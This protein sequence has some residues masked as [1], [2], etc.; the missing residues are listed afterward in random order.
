MA[1]SNGSRL[2]KTLIGTAAGEALEGG[3]GND[4]LRGGGGDDGLYGNAGKDALFGGAGNDYLVGGLGAD[5]FSG[6]S[7]GDTLNVGNWTESRGDVLFGG[8]GFDTL[9]ADFSDHRSD[10]KISVHNPDAVHTVGTLVYSGVEALKVYTGSGN[11]T[12]I[13]GRGIDSL[14]SGD[15]ND[16]IS[17]G[18]GDDFLHA[19]AGNDVVNGGDGNDVITAFD[20]VADSRSNDVVVA[21]KGNDTIYTGVGRNV[22]DAGSGNDTVHALTSN[23]VIDAGAGNDTVHIRP[24]VPGFSIHATQAVLKLGSGDDT[25]T[26]SVADDG[27]THAVTAYGGTGNDS[28][29]IDLAQL[30]ADFDVTIGTSTTVIGA[31]KLHG[32]EHVDIAT[33]SGNDTLTGSDGGELLDAGIGQDVVDGRGGDD[34]LGIGHGGRADGGS[35]NDRVVLN[36]SAT[37][38]GVNFVFSSAT[39]QVDAATSFTA[40]ESMAFRGGSGNDTV[41][42]SA[43]ADL[44]ADGAGNDVIEGGAGDDYFIRGTGVLDSS[45]DAMNGGEG[46]DTLSIGGYPKPTAPGYGLPTWDAGATID[47]Q[48]QALNAG[49]AAGVTLTGIEGLVGTYNADTF[50]GS[51]A[52]E[53]FD[54][55]GGVHDVLD[56]RGGNDVL[57]AGLLSTL[58]GGAGADT[59]HFDSR[60]HVSNSTAMEVTDFTRGEDTLELELANFGFDSGDVPS[61]VVGAGVTAVG[62]EAQFLFDTTTHTLLFDAD[63]EGGVQAF[64][65]VTLAGVSTLDAS[66]LLFV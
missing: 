25:L 23:D 45:V 61:L 17:G 53:R 66:D 40:M 15:G 8:S 38:E 9:Q 3:D 30:S 54:G 57:I 46:F 49:L 43:G 50:L 1:T 26:V 58:T 39:T 27:K 5:L 62:S 12:L 64:A 16:R 22:V 2:A 24:N 55:N 19:G 6:G 29:S 13:G 63:G 48:N 18:A 34:T 47:L 42:G 20:S 10:V 7:G 14:L 56:G 51:E 37:T 33:G 60:A 32:F 36:L 65:Q 28:A 41:T 4:I 52:D 21:G 44:L 59:F 31:I 11:D 35:G